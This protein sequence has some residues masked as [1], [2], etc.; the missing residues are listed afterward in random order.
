MCWRKR[1]LIV[2]LIS[3]GEWV[4]WPNWITLL[5]CRKYGWHSIGNPLSLCDPLS[6]SLILISWYIPT[7]TMWHLLTSLLKCTSTTRDPHSL[8][9]HA[10]VPLCVNS[11]RSSYQFDQQHVQLNEP[12]RSMYEAWY[13]I[14]S[15]F[16]IVPGDNKLPPSSHSSP[17]HLTLSSHPLISPSHLTSSPSHLTLSPTYILYSPLTR[18]P[19]YIIY[20]QV[21]GAIQNQPSSA[22]T[23]RVQ[24]HISS[25][26]IRQ[27]K[28]SILSMGRIELSQYTFGIDRIWGC[29]WYRYW[30]WCL[31][32]Q[33][34]GSVA[35]LSWQIIDTP[36][37][38]PAP[39]GTTDVETSAQ[40]H[41]YATVYAKIR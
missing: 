1:S 2:S 34:L 29:G 7:S 10:H 8:F 17:S 4:W 36:S 14:S 5:Q 6:L 30:H 18:S 40:A 11:G 38:I 12:Q 22:E 21:G 27:E 31:I 35:A 20:F 26:H 19:I 15:Y 24:Y 13:V 39:T 25:V 23:K 28:Q 16:T 37:P 3:L 33:R 41:K 32:V 9:P